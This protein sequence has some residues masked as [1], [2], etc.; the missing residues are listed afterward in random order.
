MEQYNKIGY[1]SS[2]ITHVKNFIHESDLETL[3][4]YLRSTYGF[5]NFYSDQIDSDIV[6]EM[7]VSYQKAAYAEVLSN[8]SDPYDIKMLEEPRQPAHLTKWDMLIGESMS[9]HSDAETPSGLPAIAGGFYRYNITA[10]AYLTDKYLGGEIMF[11]EFDNLKIKPKAGDLLLFPS[12][13]RHCISKLV[14]GDRYTMPMFFGFDVEDSIDVEM[15]FPPREE[16][17]NPSDILFF[18]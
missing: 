13:Y 8:Y 1:S 6:K 11:P 18:E 17:K 14:S 9:V 3:T 10:I 4:S 16:G 7:L 5:G 12:R 2:G 15:V